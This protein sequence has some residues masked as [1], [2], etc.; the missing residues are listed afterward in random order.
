MLHSDK[1]ANTADDSDAT[2]C[3]RSYAVKR[4]R[5]PIPRDKDDILSAF[6]GGADAVE[7]LIANGMAQ[8][9]VE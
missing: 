3:K 6:L 7:F 2:T 5:K 4:G 1:K 9:G 8:I